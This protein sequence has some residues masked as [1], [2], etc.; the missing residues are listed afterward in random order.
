MTALMAR[1]DLEPVRVPDLSLVDP[2]V[3]AAV[4]QPGVAKEPGDD[5]LRPIDPPVTIPFHSILGREGLEVSHAAGQPADLDEAAP[6]IVV[7]DVL[8]HVGADDQ[9]V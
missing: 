9:V 7:S 4:R 6:E 2:T 3:E 1:A 8:N 5:A